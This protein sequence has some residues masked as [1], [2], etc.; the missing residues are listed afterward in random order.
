MDASPPRSRPDQSNQAT[1]FP[2]ISLTDIDMHTEHLCDP[3]CDPD[4]M[5]LATA[6]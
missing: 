6:R 5:V 2:P 3:V 4:T 1:L